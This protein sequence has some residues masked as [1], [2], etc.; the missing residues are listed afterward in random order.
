MNDIIDTAQAWVNNDPDPVT[1]SAGQDLI[2]QGNIAVLTDH[3][4]DRLRFGTAGMRGPMGPG[5]NRMN[6]AL[7]RQVAAG[8][9]SYLNQ[10]DPQASK[11]GVVV[12]FDGRHGSR[13]FADDTA[14]VLMGMGFRVIAFDTV[15]STPQL[16]HAIPFLNAAAGVMV[17][18]S[19][20]PPKDNG[21]KV[22]WRNGAQI[23]PPHDRG[24]SAKID[25]VQATPG[26]SGQRPEAVPSA[27]WSDY[28]DRVVSL[29]V[30][31]TTGVR[32]VYTAMHG[33]GWAPLQMVM[34]AA[35]HTDVHPVKEQQEP[36]GDFPTVAFPNP[37]EDGALDLAI[38]HAQSV[39]AD[40]IIA[41]DPD[42][43][44]LA[45]ALPDKT[46]RWRSLTGNEVGVLLAE[47]LLAYGAAHPTRLVAT[48]I[49]STTMLRAIAKS[50]GA[51][52][53][54][55]LTGFKWLANLAL[56]HD[57]PFVLGFEEALGY[58]IGGVVNDKDGISA[59]LLLMDLASNL[60]AEGRTLWDALERLYKRHGVYKT[61]QISIKMEGAEGAE[62]IE[63]LMR[64]LREQPP[65]ELADTDVIRMRDV[66]SRV[67]LNCKT[68]ES[69][70]VPLPPSNV[71]EFTLEDQSRVLAR[72]SG[73][74]PKMKLY[75]E[76]VGKTH[77]DAQRRLDEVVEAT[78]ALVQSIL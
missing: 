5:P 15:C 16:A 4:G 45:V 39:G 28:L 37:E 9:G 42:A 19:H 75:I 58:S 54:E 77:T 41:N 68:G 7:V 61:H 25:S 70:E 1:R 59:A 60:K 57:G 40:I 22:Y 35:G 17:T 20:N 44:R 49:V 30:R 67:D 11:D 53:G 14:A 31:P 26:M 69:D 6:R 74:E 43:D 33:V 73:T 24:I 76:V 71:L 27:V 3:F 32:A 38:A 56:A 64:H 12:G 55:T 48:T 51:L 18:A 66:L 10:V 47:E 29:R 78:T 63:A 34:N 13:E 46:G 52:C 36:D 2:D 62:S 23:I 50:H 72:P 21:Y 65:H 8:L